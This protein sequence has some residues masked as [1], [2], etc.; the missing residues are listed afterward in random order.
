MNL[1][2]VLRKTDR[3][4]SSLIQKKKKIFELKLTEQTLLFMKQKWNR[5]AF[6]IRT[7]ENGSNDYIIANYITELFQFPLK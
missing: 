3:K 4:C 2:N 5:G 6:S 1:L 7:N